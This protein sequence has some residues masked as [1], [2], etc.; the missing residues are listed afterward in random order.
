MYQLH[1]SANAAV[2]IIRLD[3]FYQTQQH[4]PKHVVDKLDTPDN[5]VLIWL[6]YPYRIITLG[7]NK[8]NG[9]DGP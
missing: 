9:G 4:W 6:L 8:H 7:Y 3:T 2:A 5:I 1:V